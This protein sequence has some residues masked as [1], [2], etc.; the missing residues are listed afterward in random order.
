MSERVRA[1]RRAEL[2]LGNE[3]NE[4]NM[5][6]ELGDFYVVHSGGQPSKPVAYVLV[7]QSCDLTVRGKTGNRNLKTAVLVPVLLHDQSPEGGSRHHR[8]PYFPLEVQGRGCWC[9]FGKAVEVNLDVL[10]MAVLRDD[11]HCLFEAA[12][13]S[14]KG[15][16]PGWEKR[17]KSLENIRE[18]WLKPV[19]LLQEHARKCPVKIKDDIVQ[20]LLRP[21]LPS[22][23][24]LPAPLFQTGPPELLNFNLQR[25][26]RVLEPIAGEL[27]ARLR[28][29]QARPALPADFAAEESEAEETASQPAVE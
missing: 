26:G 28:G 3:I 9:D 19:R 1:L 2:Y 17:R 21:I 15:L 27:L 11:G 20:A 10:D 25:A 29:H 13:N 16:A 12:H 5:P 18:K 23:G 6:L 8:L 22:S 14:A 4:L 24:T 7:A